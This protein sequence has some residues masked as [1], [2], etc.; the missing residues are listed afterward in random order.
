MSLQLV[1]NYEPLRE[2][3][4]CMPHDGLQKHVIDSNYMYVHTWSWSSIMANHLQLALSWRYDWTVFLHIRRAYK[5][6]SVQGKP[7]KTLWKTLQLGP[8]PSLGLLAVTVWCDG[9]ASDASGLAGLFRVSGQVGGP[10]SG[11]VEIFQPGTRL[12]T[13]NFWLKSHF[14]RFFF[15][16]FIDELR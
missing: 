7:Q 16:F 8:A 14:F 2:I 9:D 10:G 12:T 4:E 3:N 5:K 11:R 6:N 13:R 1:V 15:S